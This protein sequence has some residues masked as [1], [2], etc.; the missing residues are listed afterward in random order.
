MEVAAL[1]TDRSV[2]LNWIIPELLFYVSRAENNLSL[3][4]SN[5][6]SH[7]SHKFPIWS[8]SITLPS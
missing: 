4:V 1:K 6:F 7:T 3:K 5:H 2:I 8:N